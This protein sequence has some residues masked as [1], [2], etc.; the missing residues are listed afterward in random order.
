M[1][2]SEKKLALKRFRSSAE[3]VE[4][5]SI[6]DFAIY[7]YLKSLYAKLLKSGF[8]DFFDSLAIYRS[9]FNPKFF[10]DITMPAK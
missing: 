9:N 7:K 6:H 4:K 3:T 10:T 2:N 5:A 8:L 1:G